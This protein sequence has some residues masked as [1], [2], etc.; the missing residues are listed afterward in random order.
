MLLSFSVDSMLPYVRAGIRQAHGE[1]VRERVK[2]Q[3]IRQS[4]PRAVALLAAVSAGWKHEGSLHLWWKSR[5]KEREF[6]GKVDGFHIYPLV[7]TRGS[8]G[9]CVIEGPGTSQASWDP[10]SGGATFKE[11]A[12]ADGFESPE[13]FRDYFVPNPGD[14][15]HAVIFKW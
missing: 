11:L 1:T 3:T 8:A 5:T 7:I 2:R 10:A 15:F 4:G 6:L 14:V 13:S 12:R 9:V